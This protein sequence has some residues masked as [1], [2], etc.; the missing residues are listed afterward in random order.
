MLNIS[1]FDLTPLPHLIV[2]IIHRC[3]GI[4]GIWYLTSGIEF[5]FLH[6]F[7]TLKNDYTIDLFTLPPSIVFYFG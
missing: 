2:V 5:Y 3:V 6:F 7:L 4:N 1:H